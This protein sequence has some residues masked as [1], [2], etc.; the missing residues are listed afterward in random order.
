MTTPPRFPNQVRIEEFIEQFKAEQKEKEDKLRKDFE[1]L[2]EERKIGLQRGS[3]GIAL[4]ALAASIFLGAWN[5]RVSYKSLSTA[6]RGFVAARL[7]GLSK[8]GTEAAF[9][10]RA[11]PPNPALHI[12]LDAAC[13]TYVENGRKP[14]EVLTKLVS[15]ETNLMLAPGDSRSYT[16]HTGNSEGMHAPHG[17]IQKS[18]V[19]IIQY[20]D[21]AG[22]QFHTQFCLDRAGLSQQ[23]DIDFLVACPTHNDAD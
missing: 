13:G 18:L 14:P 6:R 3:L 20:Q 9:D 1:D 7:E 19:G 15:Y 21:L 2:R 23:A 17:V 4:L 10:I 11:V 5:A 12:K 16:C 8:D 22:N